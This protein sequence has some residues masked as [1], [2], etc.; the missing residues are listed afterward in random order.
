MS[1]PSQQILSMGFGF[2]LSQ[3]LRV[4]AELSIADLLAGGERSAD[5]LAEA[6]RTNADALYRVM[7]LLA[8]EGV[9]R[10]VSHRRFVQTELSAAL[11][12]DLQSSPRDFIRMINGEAFQ[13]FAQLSYSVQTGKPAFDQVFGAPRF[14]WLGAHPEQAAL[15]QRGMIAL[16]QGSNEAVA[17]AYDFSASR[18]VV[19]VGGGHGQ[20]LSAI[21]ARNAHL[22]GVLF[23]LPSG[24]AA[25]RTAAGGPLPRSELVAGNFFESVPPADTLVLKKV[26]HDWDDERAAAILRNCRKAMASNGRILLAETIIPAGN[27]PALIKAIDVTMLA[28]PGGLERTESQY[29][30][31]LSLAGLR[32][33]RVIATKAPISILEARLA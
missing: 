23:D 17:D 25:A 16:S 18:C 11:R 10:E 24:I 12:S 4:V 13:A 7:R 32:L 15:F 33:E 21:L 27:D 20:L 5:E 22:H 29:A 2:A 26:I 30:E 28:V 14:E 31:L 19:D 3:S 1:T 9:F 6:T 8:S